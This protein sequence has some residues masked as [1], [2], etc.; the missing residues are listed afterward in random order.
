MVIRVVPLAS[1]P[2]FTW[3]AV[4]PVTPEVINAS[5]AKLAAMVWLAWTFVKV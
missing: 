5:C 3:T 1:F 2:D 4:S